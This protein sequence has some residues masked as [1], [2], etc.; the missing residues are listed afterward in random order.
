MLGQDLNEKMN[1][2]QNNH[3]SLHVKMGFDYQTNGHN[4]GEMDILHHIQ[5]VAYSADVMEN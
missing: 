1:S 4:L 2:F 3:M 5:M